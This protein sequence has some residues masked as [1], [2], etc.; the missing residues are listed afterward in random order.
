TATPPVVLCAA[1]HSRATVLTLRCCWQ[2][3]GLAP[4][5]DCAK[6]GD[7]LFETSRNA[8]S[9]KHA[10]LLGKLFLDVARVVVA[11]GVDGCRDRMASKGIVGC[12]NQQIRER[13]GIGELGIEPTRRTVRVED[14]R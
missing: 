4:I 8:G 6:M 14:Q 5:D 9:G 10:G 11:H 3:G 13:G 12:R 7:A 1:V 2:R